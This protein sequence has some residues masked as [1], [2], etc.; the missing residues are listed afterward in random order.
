MYR[1]EGTWVCMH[2]CV[3]CAAWV[4]G[5]LCGRTR[6]RQESPLLIL[7]GPAGSGCGSVYV[8]VCM[9]CV[10]TR[11]HTCAS[12]FTCVA[13]STPGTRG[14]GS[15]CPPAP[16][17]WLQPR[18][19]VGEADRCAPRLR[20]HGPAWGAARRS[21]SAGGPG[22]C[23]QDPSL[24]R[25]CC[26]SVPRRSPWQLCCPSGLVSSAERSGSGRMGPP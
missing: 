19:A 16:V 10:H 7:G 15:R 11:D 1:C 13:G 22:R 20:T 4:R 17:P 21:P 8:H 6:C 26:G 23:H 14:C 12:L 3:A 2:A 24:H 9:M 25:T 5:C 18:R